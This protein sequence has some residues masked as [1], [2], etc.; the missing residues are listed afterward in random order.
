MT[1]VG[2]PSLL[3]SLGTHLEGVTTVPD[4]PLKYGPWAGKILAGAEDEDR[5]YAVAADGSFTAFDLGISPED[6]EVIPAN[7]NFFG[8][9]FSGST[10]WGAPPSEFAGMVGDI[11]VSLESAI[12]VGGAPLWHV[13]WTGTGSDFQATVV[14][15]VGQWE[16]ITFSTAGLPNILPIDPVELSP[17]TAENRP[18]R[19]TP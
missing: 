12:P 14:A 1:S 5:I 11:L 19:T 4:D 17:I 15:E 3:A 10:L 7:Q 6:L 13:R 9:D 8:V 2:V 16:H 18:A